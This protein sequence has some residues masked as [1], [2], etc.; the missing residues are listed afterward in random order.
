MAVVEWRPWDDSEPIIR[1]MAAP[2]KAGDI[3]AWYN[4]AAKV[5]PGEDLPPWTQGVQ[6]K[7]VGVEVIIFDLP[8]SGV[9]TIAR[10]RNMR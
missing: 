2:K 7:Y 9:L 8:A 4:A 6:P 5:L 10:K 1:Q 3:R